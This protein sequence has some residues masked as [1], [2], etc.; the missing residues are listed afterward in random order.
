MGSSV[1]L[2]PGRLRFI[3]NLSQ[4][5]TRLSWPFSL[6]G[7]HLAQ[8]LSRPHALFHRWLELLSLQCS[9][10]AWKHWVED[11][12]TGWETQSQKVTDPSAPSFCF[13]ETAASPLGRLLVPISRNTAAFSGHLAFL[14]CV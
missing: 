13:P 5:G 2:C 8:L 9:G 11:V 6:P 3:S 1:K 10:A 14:G 7:A 12:L 4:Q